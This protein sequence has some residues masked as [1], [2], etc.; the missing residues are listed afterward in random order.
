LINDTLA[1]H[2]RISLVAAIFSDHDE[3]EMVGHLS[4][5]DTQAFI[6]IIDEAGPYNSTL[7]G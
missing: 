7:K 5:D 4:V 6:D 2:E 1:A 3:V